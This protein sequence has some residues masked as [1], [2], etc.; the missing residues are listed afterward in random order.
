M[1]ANLGLLLLAHM[2]E[3]ETYSTLERLV[4]GA[5]PDLRLHM[6]PQEEASFAR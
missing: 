2:S 5:S 6:S 1:A 3:A 4:S